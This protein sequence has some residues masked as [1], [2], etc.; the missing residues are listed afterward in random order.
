MSENLKIMVLSSKGGVGKSTIAMQLIAPYLFK[1]RSQVISF[2]EFDDENSD[3]LSY[4]ASKLTKREIV[5]VSTHILRDQI[6]EIISK[7]ETACFDVGGNKTTTMVLDAMSESGMI[8]FIDLVVIP[9]LDGEQDGI[10]ASVVYS[11]IKDMKRN[12]KVLFVLNR[13]K[14]NKYIHYQF[15]NFFGDIRGIFSD[16]NSVKNYLVNEDDNQYVTMLDDEIVKFSRRF[17]LTIYEI[18]HQ[19][20]DFI[21]QLKLN[22]NDVSHEQEVKLLSFKNYIQKASKSYLEDVLNPAYDKINLLMEKQD[23]NQTA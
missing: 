14:N 2:Y 8:H 19:E 4:G 1:K 18:A 3:C 20:K 21:E 16:N 9:L 12:Q 5:E 11:I 17:G 10:N 22:M 13:A 15:D 6:T 23:D 7:D